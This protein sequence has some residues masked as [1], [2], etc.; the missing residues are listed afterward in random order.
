MQLD[1]LGNKVPP[2]EDVAEADEVQ[3]EH[4]LADVDNNQQGHEHRNSGVSPAK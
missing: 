2:D 1:H 3:V 4:R